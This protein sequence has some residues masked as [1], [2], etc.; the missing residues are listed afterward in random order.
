MIKI[1]AVAGLTRAGFRTTFD[2]D[3]REVLPDPQP[4]VHALI[5]AGHPNL[6]ER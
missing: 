6:L 1:V 2:L 4:L 3:G 5:T